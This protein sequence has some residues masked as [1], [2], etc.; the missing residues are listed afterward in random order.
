MTTQAARSIAEIHPRMPVMLDPAAWST[1]LDPTAIDP[2]PLLSWLRPV[3]DARIDFHPVGDRVNAVRNDDPQ[4]L[5]PVPEGPR[6]ES[7]FS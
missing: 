2:E 6:Q 1:W 7:L 3:E 5:A 4:C